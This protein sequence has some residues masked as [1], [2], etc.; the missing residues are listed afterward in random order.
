MHGMRGGQARRLNRLWAV[1]NLSCRWLAVELGKYC[2]LQLLATF[3][4]K[5]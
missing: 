1:E 5:Q 4:V 3:V 2:S